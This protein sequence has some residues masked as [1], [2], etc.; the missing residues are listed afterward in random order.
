[1]RAMRSTCAPYSVPA[2]WLSE[3]GLM[4]CPSQCRVC[5]AGPIGAEP[6][7]DRGRAP[8][9][10]QVIVVEDENGNIMWHGAPE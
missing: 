2:A 4:A 1:M 5:C 8:L 9:G 6:Q 3:G 7:V 10:A